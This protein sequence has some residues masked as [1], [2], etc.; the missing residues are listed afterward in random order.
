MCEREDT[1]SDRLLFRCTVHRAV[2][3]S[4]LILVLAGCAEDPPGTVVSTNDPT[5]SVLQAL[6]YDYVESAFSNVPLIS[7]TRM[8]ETVSFDAAGDTLAHERVR[9][10]VENGTPVVG[11][12]AQ[13]GS[14]RRSLIG[15]ALAPNPR[16]LPDSSLV[17]SVLPQDAPFLVPANRHAY[18]MT[19]SSTPAGQQAEVRLLDPDEVES[20]VHRTVLTF[21]SSSMQVIALEVERINDTFLEQSRSITRVELERRSGGWMPATILIRKHRDAPLQRPY[22]FQKHVQYQY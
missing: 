11:A 1:G 21:D 6:R 20:D 7:H 5:L 4:C 18:E 3:I 19:L 17:L 9:I 8:I 10:D 14:F 15:R 22:D 13:T 2:T 16:Y 12:S